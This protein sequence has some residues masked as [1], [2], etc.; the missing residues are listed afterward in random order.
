MSQL[1]GSSAQQSSTPRCALE[2][3]NFHAKL[4]RSLVVVLPLGLAL[5][6]VNLFLFSSEGYVSLESTPA[7]TIARPKIDWIFP[8]IWLSLTFSV[9]VLGSV[10][11]R[12]NR[13]FF[14]IAGLYLMG[15]C[16]WMV[17]AGLDVFLA[18]SSYA[19]LTPD[20][21]TSVTGTWIFP[22]ISTV[23]FD[24]IKIA[25]IN[26]DRSESVSRGKYR[27]YELHFLGPEMSY[28]IR[29]NDS[30]YKLLPHLLKRLH[31]LD[32]VLMENENGF[33]VPTDIYPG[34]QLDWTI[35]DGEK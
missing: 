18:P 32:I 35:A 5:S 26:L 2:L 20:H 22:S 14:R 21:F 25:S 31:E 1:D 33:L 15:M 3:G 8:V 30:V 12:V 10:F 17:V 28:V 16:V 6:V 11:F 19:E 13:W 34:Y 24:Q 9:G 23:D 7:S 4:V 29:I 27:H